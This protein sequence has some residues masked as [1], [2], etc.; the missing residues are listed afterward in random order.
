MR[1]SAG[2]GAEHVLSFH[3]EACQRHAP[4]RQIDRQRA[5]RQFAIDLVVLVDDE[6]AVGDCERP[7]HPLRREHVEARKTIRGLAELIIS[8]SPAS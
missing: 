4:S 7:L 3:N 6:I 8:E 5:P 2:V 1:D